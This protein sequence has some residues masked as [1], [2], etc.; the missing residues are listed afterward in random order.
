MAFAPVD[1]AEIRCNRA[2]SPDAE[3][4][5]PS[6][7]NWSGKQKSKPTELHFVRSEADT[8]AVVRAA[9]RD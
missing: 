6:W 8:V 7:K 3:P 2:R 9:V 1:H 4:S 5:M